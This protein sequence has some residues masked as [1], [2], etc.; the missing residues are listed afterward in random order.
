[1][2]TALYKKSDNIDFD[3]T[4]VWILN[5]PQKTIDMVGKKGISILKSGNDRLRVTV[6]LAATMDGRMLQTAV[7]HTPEHTY[8]TINELPVWNQKSCT[9][10]FGRMADYVK[11]V[12]IPSCKRTEKKQLVM[13]SYSAHLTQDVNDVLDSNNFDVAVI[14]V[15]CTKDLQ[16]L[17]GSPSPRI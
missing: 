1:M 9:M 17:A 3:K 16:P 15:G 2:R 11:R 14:P 5:P 7:M 8:R 13:D 6:C 10:T 4:P 12:L